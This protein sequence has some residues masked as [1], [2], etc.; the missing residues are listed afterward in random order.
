MISTPILGPNTNVRDEI[1]NLELPLS[2]LGVDD[3][4]STAGSTSYISSTSASNNLR[5]V[6]GQ[7]PYPPF[8]FYD[9]RGY[10]VRGPLRVTN[11][12]SQDLEA[13]SDG[14]EEETNVDVLATV[15]D[16]E[17]HDSNTTAEPT[18]ERRR[19]IRFVDADLSGRSRSRN[20]PTPRP[21]DER[22][23]FEE[24][25][26][27]RNS[28]ASIRTGLVSVKN[29][30]KQWWIKQVD[31]IQQA[32][33]R[34]KDDIVEETGASATHALQ[35][36]ATIETSSPTDHLSNEATPWLN[37]AASTASTQPDNDSDVNLYRLERVYAHPH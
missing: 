33:Y 26:E 2:V 25:M 7:G 27:A 32:L 37:D 5:R 6:F 11:F 22:R 13:I 34:D 8:Y 29:T 18:N 30:V 4:Q 23:R 10:D 9:T 20:S 36:S 28:K 12:T 35:G 16:E 1:P 24:I 21:G 15:E 14:R 3:Y 31:S 19:S 17:E